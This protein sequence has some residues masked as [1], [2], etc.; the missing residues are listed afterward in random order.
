MN[1]FKN[2][3]FKREEKERL[4]LE[5]QMHDDLKNCPTVKTKLQKF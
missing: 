5:K 4:E 2:L 3:K 1:L